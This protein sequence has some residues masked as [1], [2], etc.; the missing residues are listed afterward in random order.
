MSEK[1][2]HKTIEQEKQE[3]KLRVDQ[4]EEACFQNL[5]VF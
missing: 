5:I 2:L 3:K 1:N 4:A